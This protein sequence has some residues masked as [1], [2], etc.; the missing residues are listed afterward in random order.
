MSAQKEEEF[1][2]LFVDDVPANIKILTETLKQDYDVVCCDNGPDALKIAAK[3]PQP[4]LILLDIMMPVMNGF[5]VCEKLKADKKTAHMPVIFVTALTD[6]EDEERGFKL[7]AVDFV[8]KPFSLP[9][10]RARL[11]IQLE[12]KK[13]RDKLEKRGQELLQLNKKLE[14]EIVER[15]KTEAMV[16]EHLGYLQQLIK[17]NAFPA[18]APRLAGASKKG[19]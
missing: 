12:L 17:D 6:E 15:T 3:D 2:I 10:I 14:K 8:R 11:K 13:H 1:R 18:S 19:S 7:G 4:D 16:Q 5:E 9:I